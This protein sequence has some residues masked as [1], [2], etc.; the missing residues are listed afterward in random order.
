MTITTTDLDVLRATLDAKAHEDRARARVTLMLV[1]VLS[2]AD[3]TAASLVAL[4]DDA[5]SLV[6][7]IAQ[8]RNPRW[9]PRKGY[10]PSPATRHAVA[11]LLA[12]REAHPDPFAG[13]PQG[14]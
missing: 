1:D 9:A 5:W 4:D 12:Q 11:R 14:V 13:F 2:D 8:D 3:A 7:R 10:L 6:V